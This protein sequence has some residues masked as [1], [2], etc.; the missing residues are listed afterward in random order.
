MKKLVLF[1]LLL[2]FAMFSTVLAD[3]IEETTTKV[4]PDGA[5]SILVECDFGAGELTIIPKKMS[6]VAVLD[7]TY[8]PRKVDY[9]VSY[10]VRRDVGHLSLESEL[11]R[12][13]DIEDLENDWELTLSTEYPTELNL[14]VGACEADIDLGGIPLTDLS[15]E[16]GAADGRL[17]WSKPNPERLKN[18]S[19]EV[20]AAS[21]VVSQLGN[22][23]FEYMT[24]ECGA[25]S[26]ELDFRGDYHGESVV[27]IEVGLGSIEIVVPRGLAIR[28]ES[29]DNSWFSSIDFDDLDLGRGRR[30]RY[31][32]DDFET[33]TDRLV[34]ILQ[35][36]MGSIDITDRR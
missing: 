34:L 36:G 21:L 16:I 32:S 11:V 25:A 13:R 17:E 26:C 15:I 35:V 12:H 5:K 4:G 33:A 9:D 14:E 20:G 30:G 7:V 3:R 2:T 27:D 31:E 18:L 28:I 10:E 29:D 23:N 1:V 8:E 19:I 22:A 6:D 24:L